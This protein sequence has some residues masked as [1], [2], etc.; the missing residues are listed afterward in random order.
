MSTHA[1][2][3]PH[4]A[5]A[6]APA[7]TGLHGLIAEFETPESVVQAAERAYADGYRSMDAY[8]PFPIDGLAEAIGFQ[9]NKV[10]LLVLIGGLS[11]TLLAFLMQW[12]TSVIDYPII[13]GGRPYNTWPA[14]VVIMFELTILGA[15]GTAVIGMLA[16]NGLPRPYHP[17]F[18][19]PN[20]TA[21]S[22]DRFFL[23]I[24][25]DDPRFDLARTRQFL[26]SQNPNVISEVEQ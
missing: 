15:A 20:F 17:I 11:G 2:G 13:V 4:Q 14:Y 12:Y 25:A 3:N 16:L 18:N 19:A 21:A 22:N 8:S 1:A 24:Q 26:E 5:A 6:P 7:T 10:A 23:C 9:R